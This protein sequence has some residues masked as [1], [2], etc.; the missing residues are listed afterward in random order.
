MH[1]KSQGDG[2]ALNVVWFGIAL[3]LL[4]IDKPRR[5]L[6]PIEVQRSGARVWTMAVCRARICT[7]RPLGRVP[8][9]WPRFG[10]AFLAALNRTNLPEAVRERANERCEVPVVRC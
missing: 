8:N 9:D 6:A 2:G 5:A 1:D 7:G 10:G 4:C 3:T